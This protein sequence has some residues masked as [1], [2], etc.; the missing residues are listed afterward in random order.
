L[1][2]T[3][4]ARFNDDIA[5]KPQMQVKGEVM[6]TALSVGFRRKKKLI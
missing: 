6:Y 3:P 1:R 5:D 4:N 2:A